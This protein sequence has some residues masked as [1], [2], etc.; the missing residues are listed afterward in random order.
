MAIWRRHHFPDLSAEAGD[1]SAGR[2]DDQSIRCGQWGAWS[3][4]DDAVAGDIDNSAVGRGDGGDDA[5]R[6]SLFRR[7]AGDDERDVGL[8]RVVLSSSTAATEWNDLPA[9]AGLFVPLMQRTLGFLSAA[10]DRNLNVTVGEP[11]VA[12]PL[13][14]LLGQDAVVSLPASA[15]GVAES[16]QVEMVDHEPTVTYSQT[17]WAGVY[18]MQLA[19]KTMMFGVQRPVTVNPEDSESNPAAM[20]AAQ[21]EKL[22]ASADVVR[23]GQTLTE[24]AADRG[25]ERN[26]GFSR[27]WRPWCWR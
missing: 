26:C 14:E 2:G 10:G 24:S 25:S 20:T 21:I 11:L 13:P 18:G 7:N 15:G 4:G 5:H 6:P 3:G 19:D 9:N 12:H 23:P 1:G 17:N 27:R 16:R 22:A 8:G